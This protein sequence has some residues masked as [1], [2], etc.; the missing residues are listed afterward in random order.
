MQTLFGLT[1]SFQIMKLIF[2]IT[3]K[4]MWSLF[5]Q[6]FVGEEDCATSSK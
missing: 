4:G 5:Q 3:G 6:T 2:T 1:Q